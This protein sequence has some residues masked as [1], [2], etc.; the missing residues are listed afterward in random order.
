MEKIAKQLMLIARDYKLA[1]TKKEIKNILGSVQ[2]R[3]AADNAN[4]QVQQ[5]AINKNMNEADKA[6]E[7][8][9][10]AQTSQEKEEAL[11]KAEEWFEKAKKA[12]EE[13]KEIKEDISGIRD[14][15]AKEVSNWNSC[16]KEIKKI[17]SGDKG[18]EEVIKALTN[19]EYFKAIGDNLS[20]S[21]D[22]VY[23]QVKDYH[24]DRM[25]DKK[26]IELVNDSKSGYMTNLI[27]P[28]VDLYNGYMDKFEELEKLYEKLVKEKQ[29]ELSDSDKDMQQMIKDQFNR[30]ENDENSDGETYKQVIEQ[31]HKFSKKLYK[32]ASELENILG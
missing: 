19:N 31:K 5:E 28:F 17:F 15:L 21:F 18:F 7:E 25:D 10:N 2:I 20:D 29:K 32:I 4:P 8:A 14:R 12:L 24:I 30:T 27:D 9:E 1:E 11:N 23:N 13:T 3:I 26:F 22:K 6:L 16:L